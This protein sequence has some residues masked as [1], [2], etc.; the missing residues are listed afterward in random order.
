MDG[1]RKSLYTRLLGCWYL[2]LGLA[3][4]SLGWRNFLLG[5]PRLGIVLRIAIAA[6]FLTL[7]LM[8][9]RSDGRS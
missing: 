9:L 6:G 2:C 5:A 8:T 3:F 7:G 1:P 4:A